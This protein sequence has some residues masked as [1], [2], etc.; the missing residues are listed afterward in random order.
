MFGGKWSLWVFVA[1]KWLAF[2]V[3]K[4]RQ[5]WDP[6]PTISP[7]RLDLFDLNPLRACGTLP[8]H[9]EL[10]TGRAVTAALPVGQ[11]GPKPCESELLTRSG[12]FFQKIRHLVY[13]FVTL[14]L[15]LME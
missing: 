15:A 4:R 12:T 8:R 7:G 14:R 10:A 2:C 1:V 6:V 11:G 13:Y 3:R 5:Y 9:I